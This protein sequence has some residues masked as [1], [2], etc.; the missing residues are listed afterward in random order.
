MQR[1]TVGDRGWLVGYRNV[2]MYVIRRSSGTSKKS[3]ESLFPSSFTAVTSACRAQQGRENW[4]RASGGEREKGVPVLR[5]TV[6]DNPVWKTICSDPRAC[7][8]KREPTALKWKSGCG[9]LFPSSTTEC[10]KD[11]GLR[12]HCFFCFFLKR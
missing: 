9:N 2:S 4:E 8:G 11:R 6:I 10:G 7:I 5:S 1:T 3:L 12:L